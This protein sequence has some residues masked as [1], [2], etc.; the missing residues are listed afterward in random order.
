MARRL[1][2]AGAMAHLPKIVPCLWFD[3]QAEAAANFYCAVF[4]ASSRLW[5]GAFQLSI[6]DREAALS[7]LALAR[8]DFELFNMRWHLARALAEAESGG[9]GGPREIVGFAGGRG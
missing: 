2:R 4:E 1:L 5:F 9:K 3:N 6:G 7:E 8:R